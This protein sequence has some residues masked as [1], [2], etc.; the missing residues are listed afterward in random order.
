MRFIGGI[1]TIPTLEEC[2]YDTD[3]EDIAEYEVFIN[4]LVESDIALD[5]YAQYH[6]DKP[7]TLLY[8]MMHNIRGKYGADITI[9]E[10]KLILYL[11]RVQ[12]S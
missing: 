6:K 12:L 7:M 8:W 2:F 5:T 3:R 10:I 9:K 4:A 11:L 1:G